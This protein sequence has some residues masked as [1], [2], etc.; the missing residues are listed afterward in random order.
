MKKLGDAS[1][2]V[3]PQ[4]KHTANYILILTSYVQEATFMDVFVAY[5]QLH[6]RS[7][8]RS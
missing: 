3:L 5:A 4:I 1:L 7:P 6:A 2:K 8:A